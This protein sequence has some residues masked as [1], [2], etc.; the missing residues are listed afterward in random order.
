[1]VARH[2]DAAPDL[3]KLPM[4]DAARWLVMDAL[5]IDNDTDMDIILGAL[6][7]NDGTTADLARQ[8]ASQPVDILVL[9]N[10]RITN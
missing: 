5:D 10:N 7:F 4:G 2:P 1:M 6:N 3:L 9:K 8:W